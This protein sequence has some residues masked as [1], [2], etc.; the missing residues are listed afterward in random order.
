MKREA[1]DAVALADFAKRN[2]SRPSCIMMVIQDNYTRK[3]IA[4]ENVSWIP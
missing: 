2:R 1:E 4:D 3:E